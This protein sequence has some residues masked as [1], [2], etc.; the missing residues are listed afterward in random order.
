MRQARR[1]TLD[2][3]DCP[4][5]SHVRVFT[6][7]SE[8]GDI[9]GDDTVYNSNKMREWSGGER[10]TV[11]ALC[12]LFSSRVSKERQAASGATSHFLDE[13]AFA[14]RHHASAPHKCARLR[15]GGITYELM[16]IVLA[17]TCGACLKNSSISSSSRVSPTFIMRRRSS[18]LSILPSWSS[19]IAPTK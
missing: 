10:E 5:Q 16:A 2:W 4:A 13:T 3:A 15:L 14:T 7:R 18:L 9:K 19:S 12:L 6:K 1:L 17:F 8:F 11:V